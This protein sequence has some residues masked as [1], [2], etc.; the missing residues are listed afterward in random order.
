MS[1]NRCAV[2]CNGRPAFY[3]SMYEDI[4]EVAMSL[5]WAVALHGSLK[6]D[7]DIMAMPWNESAAKFETLVSAI[8]GLFEDN[9]LAGQYSVDYKSKPHGRVVATI[10][11]WEDFYLDIS[12]ID[13]RKTMERIVER[14]EEELELADKEKRRC[15]AENMLQFDSAK[16]YANGIYNAIEIVKE[17]GGV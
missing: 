13:A 10:P 17:E 14:L 2:T 16:G 3:A 12:T 4:R 1:K 7:M 6:S 9:E 15:V 8:C 11:I 5:G